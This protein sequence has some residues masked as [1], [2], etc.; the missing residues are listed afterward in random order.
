MWGEGYT[1]DTQCVARITNL[2]TLQKTLHS[3]SSHYLLMWKNW[4]H[5]VKRWRESS[6]Q[7]WNEL[8]KEYL[9]L[10]KD[11]KAHDKYKLMLETQVNEIPFNIC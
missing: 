4:Q 10:T 5:E 3:V 2:S 9:V 6:F 1:D 7:L 11:C 8:S